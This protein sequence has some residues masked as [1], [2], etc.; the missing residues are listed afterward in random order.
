M[1]VCF[2]SMCFVCGIRVILCKKKHIIYLEICIS[3]L[4]E[5]S[6]DCYLFGQS[7]KLDRGVSSLL[8]EAKAKEGQAGDVGKYR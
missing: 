6:C 7:S 4:M 2:I 8:P 1:A 5:K 3:K